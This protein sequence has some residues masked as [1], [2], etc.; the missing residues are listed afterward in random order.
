M[1]AGFQK[2][3]RRLLNRSTLDDLAQDRNIPKLASLYLAEHRGL[4]TTRRI[5]DILGCD[6]S[7]S[8]LRACTATG[9]LNQH[10]K[11]IE[12]LVDAIGMIP[13][14]IPVQLRTPDLLSLFPGV[15]ALVSAC[16]EVLLKAIEYWPETISIWIGAANSIGKFKAKSTM[17]ELLKLVPHDDPRIA[18]SALYALWALHYSEYLDSQSTAIRAD[19][20]NHTQL[21]DEAAATLCQR[22][23]SRLDASLRGNPKLLFWVEIAGKLRDLPRWGAATS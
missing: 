12:T 18:A 4:E 17:A 22:Y 7:A 20:K 11:D 2:S 3:L 9:P 21:L 16:V 13:S 15:P 1:A 8:F 23:P 10:R 19:L 14:M 6:A 5:V